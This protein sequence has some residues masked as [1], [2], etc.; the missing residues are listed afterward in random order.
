MPFTQ[1][2]FTEEE[3]F[4][5]YAVAVDGFFDRAQPSDLVCGIVKECTDGSDSVSAEVAIQRLEQLSEDIY[6]MSGILTEKAAKH[7]TT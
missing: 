4:D 2:F 3:I 7:D 1:T 5:A 6:K